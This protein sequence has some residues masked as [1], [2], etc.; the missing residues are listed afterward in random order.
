MTLLDAASA[1]RERLT[2]VDDQEALHDFRVAM[3]RL[4]STLRAYQPQLAALVPA[5]LRRRLRELARAT[6]EAR[7]V[8][9]QI[10]WLEHRRNELPPARRAGVP[11]L[12]ARL[13][14]RRERAYRDIRERIAPKFD[15][16]ARRLRRALESPPA[17]DA[18]LPPSLASL[19][20]EL[21]LDQGSDLER[22]L[23]LIRSPA[24][25]VEAHAARI[26]VKRAR[27]L[28]EPVVPEAAPAAPVLRR[29]KQ[30]QQL[31]G[32]LH[33][34]HV[35]IVRLGDAA[36]E[37][38][39]ERT[40][41]LHE[42]AVAGAR[43][44]AARGP[45]PATSG[46]LALA[47]V[48]RATQERLCRRLVARRVAR[49]LPAELAALA[50]ELRPPAGPVATPVAAWPSRAPARPPRPLPARYTHRAGA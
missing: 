20:A 39:A 31:L 44:A 45:K 3:R 28:L 24:N 33:D 4:R 37:A 41:R 16:L 48:A 10:A 25:H 13:T 46:L 30:V 8:E 32:D 12:L 26:R 29:L 23:A 11:W 5:K 19:I 36:A 7:D 18:M 21:L 14:Q 35:V 27:Y 40:R 2:N 50:A 6:G 1:A 22:R 17:P 43:A 34:L 47:R 15:R 49:S 9:V 38:A 42:L